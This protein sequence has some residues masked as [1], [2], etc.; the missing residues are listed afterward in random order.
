MATDRTLYEA[1]TL[2]RSDAPEVFRMSLDDLQQKTER[3]DKGLRR[4][5]LFMYA[6]CLTEMVAFLGFLISFP[7]PFQRIGA[8]FTL[9]GFTYLIYQL[10]QHHLR[11][12]GLVVVMQTAPSVVFYRALLEQ[13]RDFHRG[14]WFWPRLIAL[15]PGPVMFMYAGAQRQPGGAPWAY[16]TLAAFV[17]L[18]LIAIPLNLRV[19]A[20]NFQRQID[21]LDRLTRED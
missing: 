4:A 13:R 6:V 12:R 21:E 5:V 10:R 16:G 8:F 14:P 17:V 11:V 15:M 18:G 1:S 3:M 9:I 19:A 2:W 20:G 7:D